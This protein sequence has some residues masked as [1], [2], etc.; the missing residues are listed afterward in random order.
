MDFVIVLFFLCQLHFVA[1]K[2]IIII[3]IIIIITIFGAQAQ[4]R[5]IAKN[6]DHDYYNE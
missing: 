5:K 6:N 3:I 4:S 1:S 2:G